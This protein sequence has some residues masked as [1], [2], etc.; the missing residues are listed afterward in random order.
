MGLIVLEAIGA[1]LALG[2]VVWWTMFSG[3][4]GGELNEDAVETQAD[5]SLSSAATDSGLGA[6]SRGGNTKLKG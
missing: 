2:F 6:D 1:L 5:Q 3:R 4:S